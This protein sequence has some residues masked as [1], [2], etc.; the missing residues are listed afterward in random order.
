[1]INNKN[2]FINMLPDSPIEDLVFYCQIIKRKKDHPGL[3]GRNNSARL[4]KP[5]YFACKDDMEKRWEEMVA[6][7][8]ATGARIMMDCFC[9]SKNKVKFE[10][11]SRLAD[12]FKTGNDAKLHRLYNT[13][14]GSMPAEKDY[15]SFLID[16]DDK[17]TSQLDGIIEMI[18][19]DG[20]DLQILHKIPT[21]QGW[22]YIMK[23][24]NLMK[25]KTKFIDL[26]MVVPD[27]HKTS[28]SL[29]YIPKS[30]GL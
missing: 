30:L 8:E 14:Y 12:I 28:P 22:H 24:F 3:D 10:M 19:L 4:V 5:Y 17:D 15:K 26:E 20:D 29:V 23:P 6:I 11:L 9:K 21:R 16:W 1:M 2:I 27:I 13:C 18:R 25:F 7:S